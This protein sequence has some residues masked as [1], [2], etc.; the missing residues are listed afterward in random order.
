MTINK[1][2]MI[3]AASA[4]LTACQNK[5]AAATAEEVAAN[6][7]G[8]AIPAAPQAPDAPLFSSGAPDC[9]GDEARVAVTDIAKS[10]PNNKLVSH[11]RNNL[12]KQIW[13]QFDLT[14]ENA[15]TALELQNIKVADYNRRIANGAY[16]LLDIR[17]IS[18][19]DEIRSSTCAAN[20]KFEIE[21]FGWVTYSIIYKLETTSESKIYAT[22]KGL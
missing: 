9:A 8:A 4:G 21:G 15:K 16:S 19:D 3:I 7:A 2:L 17:T 12:I 18:K 1:T 6:K 5:E 22:V 14:D 20:L 13:G 11:L 10:Q